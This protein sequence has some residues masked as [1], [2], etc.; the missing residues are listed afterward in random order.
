M[1]TATYQVEGPLLCMGQGAKPSF[2]RTCSSPPLPRI[3]NM[4]G[5]LSHAIATWTK[6]LHL[7]PQTTTKGRCATQNYGLT[8]LSKGLRVHVVPSRKAHIHQRNGPSGSQRLS[9]LWVISVASGSPAIFPGLQLIYTLE[10]P[11]RKP[12]G[13]SLV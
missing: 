3:K 12:R 5:R 8:S 13:V 10:L 9:D 4:S 2:F 7:D 11:G 6:R 1:C